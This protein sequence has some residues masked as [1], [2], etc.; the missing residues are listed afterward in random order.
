MNEL[1]IYSYHNTTKEFIGETK[2]DPNPV[3]EGDFLI[4]ADS[5]TIKPPK[6]NKDKQSCRFIDNKWVVAKIE[7]AKEEIIQETKEQLI[8]KNQ[9]I[10][11]G[12]ATQYEQSKIYGSITATI[13]LGVMKNKP[14]CIAVSDWINSIWKLYYERK[15]L[16][17]DSQ[18]DKSLLDF[19]VCGD[20]PYSIQEITEEI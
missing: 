11:W 2:A 12:A 13:A 18:I 17:T 16:I 1:T 6:F 15:A 7:V 9:Q 8:S 4:P 10:L 5:T 14:K 20:L 3:R 19:S